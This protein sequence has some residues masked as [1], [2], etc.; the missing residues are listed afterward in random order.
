MARRS[1]DV[2]ELTDE[3]RGE[4]EALAGRLTAPFRTV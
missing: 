4:L 3:E 2:I 1:C